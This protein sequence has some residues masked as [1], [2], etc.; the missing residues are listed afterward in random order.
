M[1]VKCSLLH[2]NNTESVSGNCTAGNIGGHGAGHTGGGYHGLQAE[3]LHLE[4]LLEFSLK[5]EY[6]KIYPI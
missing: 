4:L 3:Q 5:N 2:H 6:C 1:S